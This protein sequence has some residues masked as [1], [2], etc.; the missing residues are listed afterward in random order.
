MLITALWPQPVLFAAM[1]ALSYLG[2]LGQR[3]QPSALLS[4]I[5]LKRR[6]RPRLRELAALC[7]LIRTDEVA[8]WAAILMVVA[9]WAAHWIWIAGIDQSVVLARRQAESP[10][11]ET[12]NLLPAAKKKDAAKPSRAVSA[13]KVVP[14][15]VLVAAATLCALTGLIEFLAL[16]AA[17]H[18]VLA[19]VLT[20]RIR[21]NMRRV[22]VID[23]ESLMGSA[24]ERLAAYDPQAIL[25]FSGSPASAYQV[26]MWLS[27]MEKMDAR[28]VVLLRERKV[29]N[30][31]APTSLPVVCIPDSVAMMNFTALRSAKVAFFPSNVGKNIH[32]LRST[33]VKSVFIGH[34][35]SDKE[36]S[37][38]P[39]SKV[40]DEIWVAGQAGRDRYLRADV[41]VQHAQIV[42][43]GRPQ[44]AAI[45]TDRR[46][47]TRP[48]V[49]YA[50]TWEGWSDDLHHT[51]II[52]MGPRLVRALVKLGVRV[53]YKPH[54]L[55]G[56]RN[57]D[58]GTAH[59]KIVRILTEAGADHEIVTG[60]T[61]HL[62]DC[63]NAADVL[64]SDISSVISDFIASGKPY[65]VTNVTAMPC[66]D[67]R[68]RYP[69]TAAAYLL[70]PE[71]SELGEVV[72]ACSR[73]DDPMAEERRRLRT[74]LLG[75]DSPDALTRFNDALNSLLHR[76]SDDLLEL[77]AR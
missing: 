41:G 13:P 72:G 73:L 2:E 10:L 7:L 39:F 20:L 30:E 76:E 5:H 66:A 17:V 22:P 18:L 21:R 47:T 67:F 64:I 75:S 4:M 55:T 58:A 52:S 16:A 56:N 65:A 3:R 40:Y 35:D 77:S 74:Y 44:L 63:F 29:L 6:V 1:L 14:E 31:L 61:P 8:G 37:F 53:V 23:N 45:Q 71:L 9:L 33:K 48:T 11:I 46:I 12:R 36:A 57:A 70:T 28:V 62:Y 69:S 50:P 19:V 49:L 25:Y 60:P 34:G 68:E 42:E 54:P 15:T 38:N 27:T 24:D 51:S 59:R 32:M 26:N 43:V